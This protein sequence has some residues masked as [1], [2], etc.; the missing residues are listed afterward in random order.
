MRVGEERAS[1]DQ[2]LA[3]LV[4]GLLIRAQTSMVETADSE[5]QAAL[6]SRLIGKRASGQLPDFVGPH[7]WAGRGGSGHCC[8]LCDSMI[9]RNQ[10]EFEVE[11]TK[12][13]DLKIL[14]FHERCFWL[15]SSESSR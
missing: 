12:G 5:K 4:R 14:R 15:W 3:H 2:R 1:I 9:D 10:I 11:W 6:R 8:S 13:A 7:A